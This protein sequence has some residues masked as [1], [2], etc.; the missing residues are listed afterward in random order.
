MYTRPFRRDRPSP[1]VRR[2]DAWPLRAGVA[3]WHGVLTVSRRRSTP[4]APLV[5]GGARR[6]LEGIPSPAHH[7][8]LGWN[9]FSS[10]RRT[11]RCGLRLFVA[12]FWVCSIRARWW[13]T[14]I[15]AGCPRSSKRLHRR[16]GGSAGGATHPLA[17]VG[18]CSRPRPIATTSCVRGVVIATACAGV[19]PRAPVFV[20]TWWSRRF[21]HAAHPSGTPL[22]PG[23]PRLNAAASPGSR[24]H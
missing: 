20:G 18:V 24:R 2:D 3:R 1:G 9:E 19:D 6:S 10:A 11:R 4:A 5:G 16:I 17:M 12:L 7:R 8:A 21:E 22:N 14:G 15:V 23:S 13:S